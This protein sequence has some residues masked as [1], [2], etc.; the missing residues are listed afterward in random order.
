MYRQSKYNYVIET[1]GEYCVY[2]TLY[3][4]IIVLDADEYEILSNGT[5]EKS[6]YTDTEK[7]FI[8]NGFWIEDYI[9]ETEQYL[10]FCEFMC[11]H[12][13][14]YVNAV[15]AVTTKCNARC[16]YC[17]EKGTMQ[18]D[19]TI[20]SA[21][22][23]I[24]YLKS[25][26][27]INKS[28]GITWYG[29]EPLMNQEIISYITKELKKIYNDYS[30]SMITNG[31]LFDDETIKKAVYDWKIGVV[32]ITLD[33]TEETYNSRKNYIKC[34]ESP[35]KRVINNIKRLTEHNIQVSIRLNIDDDNFDDIIYLLEFLRTEMAETE[36]IF[37][38]PAVL[39]KNN[40]MSD[41]PPEERAVNYMEKIFTSFSDIVSIRNLIEAP[42]KFHACMLDDENAVA[43]G[44]DGNR[45]LCEHY[46]NKEEYICNEN[47]SVN[48][49]AIISECYNCKIL[50][51]CLGGC[52]ANRMENNLYC[53]IE[54]YYINT[55]LKEKLKMVYESYSVGEIF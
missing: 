53:S 32:Q 48:K 43:F 8:D 40:F 46:V 49:P 1:A 23:V 17:F 52:Y 5:I 24:D 19:M 41:S 25:R 38:Y 37:I 16:F 39:T 42:H 45:Y 13:H 14:D 15:I 34:N 54:K 6:S 50:P 27:D 22:K 26:H 18:K 30:A 28:L 4:G 55:Y 7:F 10:K 31:F 51:K 35:F 44:T 9:N 12:K 2:N 36:N 21:D 33:G 11:E 47:N 3:G 29:G 20:D